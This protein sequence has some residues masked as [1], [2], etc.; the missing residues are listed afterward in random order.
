M[1]III[2][3]IIISTREV[4]PSAK[5]GING[6]MNSLLLCGGEESAKSEWRDS[7]TRNSLKKMKAW[8]KRIKH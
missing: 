8:K 2:I 5:A 7:C 4:A 1:K 6:K 3:I